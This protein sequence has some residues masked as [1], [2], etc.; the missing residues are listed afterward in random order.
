MTGISVGAIQE[1]EQQRRNIDHAKAKN[2]AI[3]ADA[4]NCSM[5]DWWNR[6]IKRRNL[7]EKEL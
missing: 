6:N 2:V 1:Y 4:L 5:E 7:E 3:L